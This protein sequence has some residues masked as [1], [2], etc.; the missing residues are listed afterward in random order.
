MAFIPGNFLSPALSLLGPGGASVGSG[1]ADAIVKGFFHYL[2]KLEEAA[3]ASLVNAVL[4]TVV[5]ATTSVS[6]SEGNSWFGAIK[7]LKPVL[8]LVVGPLLFAGTIGPVLRQ[9]LRRLARV[10]GVG[11]PVA[12]LGGIASVKLTAKGLSATD[13][14]S[15]AIVADVAPR[16]KSDFIHA[17]SAGLTSGA[18]AITLLLSVVVIAGGL[19][20]W[21]ELAVRAVAIEVA[22]FFMPLALAGV[23][24]PATS[25]FA[26]R[27]VSLLAALLLMKPVIVG[28][29][30]LGTAALTANRGGSVVSGTAMLLIAAF[31][32]LAL[33][34]M[35]PLV[36]VSSVAHLHDLS[37]QPVRAADRA[38]RGALSFAT[39]ARAVTGGPSGGR[40]SGDLGVAGM[41]LSQAGGGHSGGGHSGGG[42]SGGGH[43]GGGHSGGGPEDHPLGPARP[44]APASP[45][46]PGPTSGKPAPDPGRRGGTNA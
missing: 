42:H 4:G 16:M 19:L 17:I 18:T 31:S 27:F 9:D 33:F 30:A 29:F 24:W 11:L 7:L 25:H 35:V 38:M 41:L 3:V 12:V 8:K 1:L 2:V 37:R 45:R 21:L 22:V 20:L 10:W 43:S 6:K 23:I 13:A 26:K 40:Q 36:E 5:K 46:P 28:V 14:L 15:K 32:P 39:S 44:P 34:K